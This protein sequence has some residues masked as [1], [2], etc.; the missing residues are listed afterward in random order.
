MP[1]LFSEQNGFLVSAKTITAHHRYFFRS[2]SRGGYGTGRKTIK[3][4]HQAI[5]LQPLGVQ[6]GGGLNGKGICQ[7][8]ADPVLVDQDAISFIYQPVPPG[9]INRF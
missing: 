9:C 3:L 1:G 5:A 2:P 7:P 8:L 4:C 6:Y